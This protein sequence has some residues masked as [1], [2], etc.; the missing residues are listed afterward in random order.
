MLWKHYGPDSNGIYGGLNGVGGLEAVQDEAGT[1]YEPNAFAANAYGWGLE[2]LE[3]SAGKAFAE[4]LAQNNWHSRRLDPTGLIYMGHR[5]YS[6]VLGSFISQDP[7][8]HDTSPGLYDFAYGDP[9]NYFDTNGLFASKVYDAT[10][11]AVGEAYD[12]TLHAAAGFG[13]EL[14]FGVSEKARVFLDGQDCIDKNRP[15]YQ[16]GALVNPK[17]LIKNLGKKGFSA[18]LGA[19]GRKLRGT[20]NPSVREAIKKG[21]EA[22]KKLEKQVKQK[23]GWL[24]EPTIIGMDGKSHKPDVVTP[25]GRF[26]ELK[27]NTL[28]GKRK[29]QK[30]AERYRDQLGMEGKV[31]Y[32]NP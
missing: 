13:D 15:A 17:G 7:L 19:V 10:K 3:K 32:Y 6:P 31:I 5:Y 16:V 8:G 27:P 22:H 23:S 4:V 14:T 20:Q 30:Q 12:T 1:V 26:I 29:G 9:V 18:T 21:N 11:T 25:S 2:S 28:S 24:S